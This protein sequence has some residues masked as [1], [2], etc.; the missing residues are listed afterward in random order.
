VNNN[1][2]PSRRLAIARLPL[3]IGLALGAALLLGTPGPAFAAAADAPGG[4]LTVVVNIVAQIVQIFCALSGF[5]LTGTI[6]F[7]LAQA[8]IEAAAGRPAALADARDRIIPVVISFIVAV[9][10]NVLANTVPVQPASGGPSDAAGVIG[11]WK[12]IAV[13]LINIVLG[14]AGAVTAVGIAAGALDTQIAVLTG[15]PK[16]MAQAWMRLALVVVMGALTLASMHL[17]N[18]IIQ[19]IH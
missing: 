2:R 1:V 14:S 11:L 7:S 16:F 13:F 12:A 6:V 15:Q 8:N 3:P 5:Y 10:A 4:G 9:S 19:A 17:A 18:W